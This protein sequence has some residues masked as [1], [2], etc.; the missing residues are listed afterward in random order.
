MLELLK[1]IVCFPSLRMF[2]LSK[3]IVYVQ[4]SLFPQLRVSGRGS[5]TGCLLYFLKLN[6]ITI[7]IPGQLEF[8]NEHSFAILDLHT[9]SVSLLF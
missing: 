9:L 3:N 4:S 6:G 5:N 2:E 7:I 1:I 8:P